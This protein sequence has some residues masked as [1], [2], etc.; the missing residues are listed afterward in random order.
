MTETVATLVGRVRQRVGMTPGYD[1]IVDWLNQALIDDLVPYCEWTWLRRESQFVFNRV[2][3]T[4][5]ISIDRGNSYG[6]CSGS[7]LSQDMVGRQ[8]RVRNDTLIRTITRVSGSV[9]EFYPTWFESSVSGS[10]FEIYNAFMAV[11]ADFISFITIVDLQRSYQLNW[12]GYTIEDLN[13]VDP[14]RSHGGDMA[15]VVV[16][17]DYASD[18]IGIVGPV[19]QAR[20]AGNVPSSGGT[21]SGLSDSTIVIEMTSPTEF[22]WKKGNGSYTTA[23]VDPEGVAQYLSEGVTIS[24]DAGVSYSDGDVFTIQLRAGVSAGAA[25]YEA[26][27]HVRSEEVRPFLYRAK[28]VDL[29]DEGALIPHYIKTGFL[30]EKALAACARWKNPENKYYDPKLSIIHDTRAND[31]L[32]MMEKED[33]SREVTDVRYDSWCNMPMVDSEY[34]AGRDVGYGDV[35]DDY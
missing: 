28:P 24:F 29:Y 27:P 16:L 5:T 22:Q 11:P 3:N 23:S 6:T 2:Y 30:L 20:G 15:T 26:W 13:R 17:R 4:G 18:S 34:L 14:Q 21:Y 31:Y 32:I 1:L 10:S 9:I 35:L 19:V 7:V 12:W 8:L 33:Q 25:R